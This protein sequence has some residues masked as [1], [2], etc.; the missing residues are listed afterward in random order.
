MGDVVLLALAAAVVPALLACVAVLL[1]RPKP[2]RLLL[3]FYLG[4]LIVSVTAG[5]VIL[6]YYGNGHSVIGS[7]SSRPSPGTSI[8]EGAAALLLAW[9]LAASG[10][11]RIRAGA[12]SRVAAHRRPRPDAGGTPS[13]LQKQLDRASPPMAFALGAV[14]NLPGPYYLLA[15]GHIAEGRYSHVQEVAGVAVFNLIMFALVE[16]PLIGYLVR[17]ERTAERVT[18]VSAWLNANGLRLIGWIIGA[19]GIALIVQGLA[20]AL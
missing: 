2:R 10:G 9:L 17:P 12:R 13:K 4:G 3:A 19:A 15:L 18:V 5:L 20:A 7:T 8:V 11:E 1:A 6:G 14:I 16:L